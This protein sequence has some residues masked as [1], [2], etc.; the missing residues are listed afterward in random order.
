MSISLS[1]SVNNSS[2]WNGNLNLLEQNI[3]AAANLW[4]QVRTLL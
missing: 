4:G 1:F 2:S 3:Q